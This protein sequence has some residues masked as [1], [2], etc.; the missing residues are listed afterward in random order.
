[1]TDKL[2]NLVETGKPE[3]GGYYMAGSHHTW[4][5]GLTEG[6][7]YMI[8]HMSEYV[9]RCG[10]ISD[11]DGDGCSVYDLSAV[12]GNGKFFK[13]PANNQEGK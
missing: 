7:L 1:M 6:K 11:D 12:S 10:F 13:N 9:S 8:H 3:L 2:N 4:D 5:C